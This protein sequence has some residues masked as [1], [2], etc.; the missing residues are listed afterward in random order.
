LIDALMLAT[1][2]EVP[3]NGETPWEKS[4]FCA[5]GEEEEEGAGKKLNWTG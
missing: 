1:Y 4:S 2:F 5:R 3:C